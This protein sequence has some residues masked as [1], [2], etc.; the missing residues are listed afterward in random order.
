MDL[1][2]EEEYRYYRARVCYLC[3]KR[4]EK[5][6]VRDHDHY[7]GKYRGAACNQCN[8][9]YKVPNFIPVFFHNL[10]SYDCHLFIKTMSNVGSCIARTEEKY[11]SFSKKV[12]VEL[13]DEKTKINKKQKFKS[14]SLRFLDSLNF[15]NSSLDKLS[16]SLSKDQFKI[17]LKLIGSIPRKGIYPYDYIDCFEKFNETSLPPREKFYNKLNDTHISEEDYKRAVDEW[18][19]NGYKNIGEYH[20][21]Y[22]KSD[23]LLL[24]DVFE[25]FRDSCL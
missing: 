20:D 14:I 18:I 11:I 25:N 2:P 10:T 3:S 4:F 17:V 21:G 9:N 5:D 23:V 7:T 15:M 22:L 12:K 19:K 1:T 8:L 6:K 24:A 16:S 13:D